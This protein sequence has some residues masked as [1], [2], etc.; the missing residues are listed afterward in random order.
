MAD[1]SGVYGVYILTRQPPD[2]LMGVRG[3]GD[4]RQA[5]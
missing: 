5:G 2:V 3:G 1:I 4:A